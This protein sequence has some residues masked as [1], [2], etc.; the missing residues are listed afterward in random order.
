MKKLE[1]MKKYLSLLCTLV[2][3]LALAPAALAASEEGGTRTTAELQ[4]EGYYQFETLEE[5]RE[6]LDLDTDP[7]QEI[8]ITDLNS[9]DVT[10]QEDLLIP[11]GKVVFFGEGTLT[12]LPEVTV[13]VEKGAGLFFYGLDVQ[14]T[15]IN[16]GDLVQ[17]QQ[18]DGAQPPV[19]IS[20]EVVNR[21]WFSVYYIAEGL[22]KIENLEEGRVYS[23][24]EGKRI[25]SAEPASSNPSP[26]IQA[27]VLTPGSQQKSSG[28]T[29]K[30]SSM[31]TGTIASV[32]W[33][34]IIVAVIAAKSRVK[35]AKKS[36]Q[37]NMS[38][39]TAPALSRQT[40][41]RKPAAGV[42]RPDFGTGKGQPRGSL[43]KFGRDAAEEPLHCS[44][45][46]G[47]EKYYEQLDS[48]LK[49]GLID[50]AEYRLLKERYS[51]L[52]IEDDYH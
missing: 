47:K 18:Y 10:L 46:R 35:K 33:L 11:A 23:S 29:G 16:N 32:V 1:T 45:S 2:L 5:L 8:F 51:R 52:E 31:D 21:D 17:C 41:G 13:T 37:R 24:S 28:T 38:T 7:E 27:P 39:R 25:T 9:G 42:S 34:V 12:V 26:S 48:F 22:E 44:H 49:N 36:A 15:V 6:I 43:A 4:D 14:G 50:K 19:R 30:R 20:G 3:L 40:P